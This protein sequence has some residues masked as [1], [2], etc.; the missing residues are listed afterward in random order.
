M[1]TKEDILS[2]IEEEDVE[3]IRLQFTDV[4]G[5]LKNIAVT[6]RQLERV[7][8]RN[9]RI[10]ATSMFGDVKVIEEDLY[11]KPDLNTFV[12]LPW[13]P[14][15]GKVGKLICDVCYED[16]KP[17]EM[18]P[19]QILKQVIA[20]MEKKG[21]SAVIDPECEF[22]LFHTDENGTPTTVTHEQA[23]YM[24]VGPMDFGENARRDIA[25]TLEE[26][27]FDVRSSL[28][29]MA[30]GQHEID[31]SGA[32][33][34]SIADALVTFRFA[35][36][37]IA[38]RFGLHATFMPKPIQDQAG[39]GMHLNISLY[40]DNKNVFVPRNGEDITEAARY[41]MGGV[42]SHNPALCAITNPTVN[43]YKR[44]LSGFDAPSRAEWSTNGESGAIRLHRG[45]DEVKVE[46]RFPDSSANPYLAI[47]ASLAAGMDGIENKTDC[48]PDAANGNVTARELPSNLKV[49][50]MALEEDELVKKAI[51]LEL[52]DIYTR[53][54]KNEWD[55]Y[56]RQ[57]T[58][59]EI[60]RYLAKM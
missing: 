13:R 19:R 60:N 25:L 54:K 47:A 31:F 36:R 42:L 49:A 51:G 1:K 59:W 34:L 6:P 48:G 44:L 12:I 38:K 9:Y 21:Y 22:F 18:C 5:K 29:E 50:I 3:F 56:M 57:V 55:D 39:S 16:G 7:V 53:L 40:K 4:F 17:F 24:D 43:S 10:E 37:S 23:G 15:Q 26:M 41:F 8:D 35:V 14:Q 20:D 58:D 27:G 45:R 46:L 30:P 52:S 28:H 2:L 33:S 11:L 32:E